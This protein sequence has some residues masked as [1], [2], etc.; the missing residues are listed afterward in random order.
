MVGYAQV[1]EFYFQGWTSI[2]CNEIGWLFVG[3]IFKGGAEPC[4][5]LHWVLARLL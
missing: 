1:L 3:E 2:E 4:R 5:L